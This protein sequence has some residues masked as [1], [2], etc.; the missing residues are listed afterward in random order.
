MRMRKSSLKRNRRLKLKKAMLKQ[1]RNLLAHHQEKTGTLCL[2][3]MRNMSTSML[4]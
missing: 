2:T 3:R 1:M 4:A